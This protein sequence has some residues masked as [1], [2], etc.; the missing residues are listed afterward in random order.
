[1]PSNRKLSKEFKRTVRMLAIA[2]IMFWASCFYVF[3]A[4]ILRWETHFDWSRTDIALG[5]TISLL[6]SAAFAPLIGTLIDRGHG[7]R[8]IIVGG[9]VAAALLLA[10]SVIEF[11]W[12]FY[13]LWFFM[14]ICHSAILY[15]PCFAILTRLYAA[16]AKRAITRVTLV[17]GFAGTVSFPL[18]HILSEWFGWQRALWAFAAATV[19]ATFIAANALSH[20]DGNVVEKQ[21]KQQHSRGSVRVALVTPAF[22]LI[23][24]AFSFMALNHGALLPH[25]LPL[26]D[27]RAYPVTIA[28][29]AAAFIGPMQVVGRICMLAVEQHM[30]ITLVSVFSFLSVTMASVAL[31]F[32]AQAPWLLVVFVVLQGAGYGVTSITRPSVTAE[33][34]GRSGFGAISGTIAIP[35]TAAFA[36]GPSVA[37]YIW[38]SGGYTAVLKITALVAMIGTMIFLYAH[39]KYRRSKTRT[40]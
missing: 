29:M 16:D 40:D 3:H 15:E 34:L 19:I 5:I 39:V 27:E 9:S 1:M 17:A 2:E 33:L 7:R 22:W 26:L 25:L 23:A 10:M 20:F 35:Y 8:L 13:L 21:S 37:A 18:A 36:I 31:L 11:I 28:V 30:S 12:Q 4:L 6:C 38:V 24:V 14:G 32:S